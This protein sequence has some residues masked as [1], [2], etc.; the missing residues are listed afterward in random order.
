[1]EN[2]SKAMLMA[3]GVLI[4]LLILSLAV[5]LF[6]NFGSASAEL[7]RQNAQNQIDQFNAQFTT[8]EGRTDITMHDIVT[9]TN[10]AKSSNYS[11]ELSGPSLDNNG[12]NTTYYITVNAKTATGMKNNLQNYTTSEL[13]ELIKYDSSNLVQYPDSTTGEVSPGLRT[14]S[15]TVEISPV[16]QRV[17]TVTFTNNN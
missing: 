10:L 9:V 4:G 7:H 5:Y 1:M 15:C 16:T 14:Y 12:N 2:A 17:S 8:Y 6:A 11:Y 13:E 3:A